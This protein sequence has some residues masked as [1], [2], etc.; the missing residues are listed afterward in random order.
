MVETKEIALKVINSKNYS[1]ALVLLA[2]NR[3]QR[4]ELKENGINMSTWDCKQRRKLI[5][6]EFLGENIRD[7]KYP[8]VV[9]YTFEWNKIFEIMIAANCL[10]IENFSE[11]AKNFYRKGKLVKLMGILESKHQY[12]FIQK[13]KDKLMV[14][15]II[16]KRNL[17]RNT[18][19]NLKMSNLFMSKVKRNLKSIKLYFEEFFNNSNLDY[20]QKNLSS[21]LCFN[22]KSKSFYEILNNIFF[23]WLIKSN[24][25][26]AMN[27]KDI[28]NLDAQNL[29]NSFWEDIIEHERA[30]RDE[31]YNEEF[32]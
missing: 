27:Y 28:Q 18:Y 20:I 19:K 7:E 2:C 26:L 14:K 30:A 17:S 29:I 13:S 25:S 8:K 3:I 1:P 23:S 15:K 16:K 11:Y 9:N 21:Y 22:T 31:R 12:S 24:K 5:D 4:K 32:P 10:E 6:A